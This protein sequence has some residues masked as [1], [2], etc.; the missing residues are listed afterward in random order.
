MEKLNNEQDKS[1][2]QPWHYDAV[3]T[4][5]R[6]YLE[7]KFTAFGIDPSSIGD[8]DDL[9]LIGILDS[10]GIVELITEV[11]AHAGLNADLSAERLHIDGETD[12]FPSI[13]RL[14]LAF[15]KSG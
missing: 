1:D 11:E 2:S 3:R 10:Y 15:V 14:T 6:K 12:M 9:S 5:V 7:P 8:N 13:A 4:L